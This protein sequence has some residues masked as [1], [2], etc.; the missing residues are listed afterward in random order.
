M[1]AAAAQQPAGAPNVVLVSIDCM[2]RDRLSAYGHTRQTTPF[3]DGMLDH[4]LHATSAHSVSC[5]TC[6]SVVSLMSG[7]YPH[8]HGGGLVPGEPKN[9]SKHNLPTIASSDTPLL[10]DVLRGR[11]YATAAIG[12]VW[13]A[14]LPVPGRFDEMAMLEKPAPKLIS[15]SLKWMRAQAAARRPFFLWL[16]LGDP[17][18]PLDVPRS[19]RDVFGPVPKLKNVRTWDYQR[20][21]DDVSG[22]GFAAY[23]DARVRLYDAAV[24]AADASLADLHAAMSA[25]RLLDRTVW[26]VTADHGEEFWEHRQEELEGF[27]DPRDIY[28]VGH[29]H[30][31]FQVHVLVPL[32]LFGPGIAPGVIEQNVSLVDVAPTVLQSLAIEVPASVDGVSLLETVDPDRP[33]LSEGIAYGFEKASVVQGDRKLLSAPRDGFERLWRLGPD[34]REASVVNDPDALGRMRDAIPGRQA[35]G[36]QVERTDEIEAHLRHLG[37][38]E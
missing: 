30:N 6:P 27:T 10:A 24:R 21:G 12:A 18:E 38:I 11:G 15:R 23:A 13:N 22:P 16:H 35:M 1:T 29:G 36:E 14:H 3:L 19:L 7:Q 37:Y 4:T 34:R 2:R 25:D 26:V 8:R 28:G 20:S 5:W 31:M 9:L 33:I 17:H 32:L